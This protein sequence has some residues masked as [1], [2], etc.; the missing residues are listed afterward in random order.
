MKPKW[1]LAALLVVSSMAFTFQ[2]RAQSTPSS[3]VNAT[4]KPTGIY[5]VNEASNEQ[6]TA[7]AYNPGL[8]ASQSYQNDVA[9]HAIFVPLAQILPSITVWGQF[10]WQWAYLDTLVQAAVSHN[11]KFSI[12]LEIGFQSSNTYLQSL[13]MNFAELCGADCAPLFDVWSTGAGG[14]CISAYVPLPWNPKVQ[15]MWVSAAHELARHLHETHVYSSLT[16]IHVPG[17]SVYDEELRLPTGFPRPNQNV[18][19]PDTRYTETPDFS[20]ATDAS[21]TRWTAL[22]YTNKAAI[23]GFRHIARA[24]ANEFP[25]RFLA[26]SLFNPGSNGVNI[27]FPNVNGHTPNESVEKKIVREISALAPSRVQVQSD[28]L[29]SDFVLPEVTQRAFQFSDQIGWQ[30]NK[31]AG[32]GA[33]CNGGA[34]GSCGPDGP[35]S[36]YFQLLKA[37]AVNGG[38]YLEVWSMDVVSYPQSFDAAKAAGYFPAK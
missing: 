34:A 1:L 29:D 38:E 11:K 4:R 9:G 21:A 31:H 32:T 23:H 22:G 7:T 20:V 36:P 5:V 35:T 12:A 30:T 37:G 18:Q 27:D 17:L 14:R 25:D 33:G 3:G 28:D 2:S 6:S 13:P 26:L 10:N 19:C 8:F 15:E 16:M 24:F